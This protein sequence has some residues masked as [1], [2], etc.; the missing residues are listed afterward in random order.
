MRLLVLLA[1]LLPLIEIA[2][3]ILVGQQIGVLGVIAWLILDAVAGIMLLR[4]Q[5]LQTLRRV[6]AAFNRGEAPVTDTLDGF[7]FAMAGLLLLL[8]GFVSDVIAVLLLLPPVRRLIRTRLNSSDQG[9]ARKRPGGGGPIID[10]EN[11]VV[12]D[13]GN[14]GD[15]EARRLEGRQKPP[16]STSRPE[17]G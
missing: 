16:D 4:W 13:D 17:R 3:M 9:F 2:V 12:E 11:W 8:P 15:S 6:Q 5:G 7:A 14:G 10:A 1:L